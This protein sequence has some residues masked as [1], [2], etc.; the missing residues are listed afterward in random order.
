MTNDNNGYFLV[1]F[2][3]FFIISIFSPRMF[4]YNIDMFLLDVHAKIV[5]LFMVV[6]LRYIFKN[7]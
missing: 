7:E 4:L 6:S 5:N 3:N 2:S 1:Y